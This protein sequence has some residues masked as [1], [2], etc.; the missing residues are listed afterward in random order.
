MESVEEA[1]SR[2][3]QGELLEMFEPLLEIISKLLKASRVADAP[4]R[5]CLVFMEM[6]VSTFVAWLR[7]R[8]QPYGYGLDVDRRMRTWLSFLHVL[9]GKIRD[10][11]KSLSNQLGEEAPYALLRKAMQCFRRRRSFDSTIL[12]TAFICYC[13][14]AINPHPCCELV[15]GALHDHLVGIDGPVKELL[16]WFMAAG[17][18][19]QIMAIVGPAGIGK[20]TLAMELYHQLRCQTEEYFQ[21]YAVAKFPWRPVPNRINLLL[22]SILSQIIHLEAPSPHNSE[23]TMLEDDPELLARNI[24]EHLKD[25]RYFILIDDIFI[26]QDWEMIKG[27]FPNNNCGSLILFTTRNESIARWCLRGYDGGVH[28]MEP[29]NDSDSE[30]L[31]CIK[32]FGSMEDCPP[33][34]L[35]LL[36]GEILTMCKGIPLS[37]IGMAECLK[38]HQHQHESSAVHRAEQVRLLFKPF[39]QKP[40]FNYNKELSQSLSS[41][42]LSMFPQGF[43]FDKD[44]LT[45]KWL[46]EGLLHGYDGTFGPFYDWSY[47]SK[48]AKNSFS[49][50]VDSNII[51]SVAENCGL[52]LDEDDLCQWQINPLVQKFLASIAADMGYVFTSSTLASATRGGGNNTRIARRLALHQPDPQLPGM[53]QQVDLSHTRSLSISGAVDR[54]TVPFDKFAYLVVL[55]LEGWENLKDEDLLQICK[56]FLLRYLSVRNTGVSKLPPQIEELRLLRTLDISR[57]HISKLPSEVCQLSLVKLD[58]RGTQIRNLPDQIVQLKYTLIHFLVGGGVGSGTINSNKTVLTKIQE[59]IFH[60]RELETLATIDLSEFS[61]RSVQSLGDLQYLLVLA[62]IWSFHQCTDE[63]YRKALRSSIQRRRRLR[64]LTI[65]CGLGCSM[66]FLGSLKKSDLPELLEKFKVTAGRFVSVPQWIE[67]LEHLTFLQITVCRLDSNDVK[68]LANLFNLQCLILGLEFIPVK[69]IVIERGFKD[70]ERFSLDCPMPWLTFNPGAMPKLVYLQLKICS[71]PPNHLNA[72][73][74]GFNNLL[75]ITDVV[76]CYSK[77]CSSS[78]SIKRTVEAVKKQ[79][80]KHLNPIDLVINGIQQDIKLLLDEETTGSGTKDDSH[81]DDEEAGRTASKI[82]SEIEEIEG[83]IQ[84]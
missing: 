28:E 74:S 27:A 1:I 21:C 8:L 20:T 63:A 32:A 53:L 10:T 15:P 79:V 19:L 25:K 30:R 7:M 46:E 76:I 29:L 64:S 51:T 65:H 35:K 57:T 12:M 83:E 4:E 33:D 72:V 39:Q 38:Q 62:I 70:L 59:A 61:P 56:M 37:I 55:D 71:V 84:I 34:N 16:R 13:V 81:A 18:S 66:E 48:K 54:T 22:K 31:L 5:H 49:E 50:L 17:E 36:C 75:S 44:H 41:L 43:V 67:G 9:G 78:S 60:F 47:V 45:F 69:E 82:Q 73:P 40:S 11:V 68:I 52:N 80:L 2:E 3:Q 77:W 6:E 58:L 23:I 14:V 26:N 24:S 42:Y